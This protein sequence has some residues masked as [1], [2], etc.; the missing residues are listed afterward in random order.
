MKSLKTRQIEITSA[1]TQY[2][3]QS[4]VFPFLN[5]DNTFTGGL[6]TT[7]KTESE[8]HYYGLLGKGSADIGGEFFSIKGGHFHN[9]PRL[10][11]W[12][13]TAHDSA[14]FK[15]RIFP[16]RSWSSSGIEVLYPIE[17]T[18]DSELD[19]LGTTAISNVLPTNPVAS[20]AV[21][22]GELRDG[23]P[24]IIGS[25]LFKE[26]LQKVLKGGSKEYLNWE[27]AWKPMINDLKKFIIASVDSE[28]IWTQYRRD[29]GR[30]V[31]RRF[32]YPKLETV[33]SSV[34]TSAPAGEGLAH[35]DLWQGGVNTFEL[36]SE[37][38]IIRRRWFSGAFT[39]Y[40]EP[41][42]AVEDK[43]KV[44]LKRFQK[45]YGLELTPITLWNLAPWSW[46]V[47]WFSN[48]GDLINNITRFSDDGLVMPYGYMMEN[49]I[50]MNTYRMRDVT[51]K[52]Y[53]ISDLTQIFTTNVKYRR[54]AT[55]YG[56]GFDWANLTAR[57][58]AI[59]AALGLS[60]GK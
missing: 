31:R 48:T 35:P 5:Q 14:Y 21:F 7:Q 53:H 42:L 37:E 3:Y 50:R 30:R 13:G 9:C 36:F 59:L 46:F 17:H 27:F 57:Q 44:D 28:K 1:N 54:Q 10:E 16:F 41:D 52:G 6:F 4:L 55:P 47:D 43:F 56:F 58:I 60:R 11:I 25:Q 45:L 23:L 12:G 18:A 49:S 22:L 34:S 38:R 20:L 33:V 40:Y 19:A 39:Y 32:S 15:G 51:P 8:G 2:G 26:G 29:S 24:K